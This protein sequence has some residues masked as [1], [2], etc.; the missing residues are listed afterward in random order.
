[1]K[2]I[3]PALILSAAFC[4]P[5]LAADAGR[6]TANAVTLKKEELKGKQVSLDVGMVT[7]LAVDVKKA[8]EVGAIIFIVHTWDK[9]N[10]FPGGHMVI[11]VA[12][13]KA[14]AFAKKFGTVVDVGEVWKKGN[15]ET[16]TLRAPLALLPDSG[17]CILDPDGKVAE[18]LK[19]NKSEALSN[20]VKEADKEAAK[21]GN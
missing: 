4:A 18:A 3:L 11:A 14:D 5:L 15:V 16:K 8:E 19:G 13:D 10:K 2:R 6:N 21:K 1:M 9:E 17:L 12:K 20:L 7:R